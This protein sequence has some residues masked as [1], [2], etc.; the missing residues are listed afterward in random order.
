MYAN[1]SSLNR[2]MVIMFRDK[3]KTNKSATAP[4][5]SF[6]PIGKDTLI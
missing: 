3:M 6:V 1:L 4:I 5:M 2:K